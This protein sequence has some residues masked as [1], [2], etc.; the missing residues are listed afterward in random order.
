[1]SA[2]ALPA[3]AGFSEGGVAIGK[4]FRAVS[5]VA[6]GEGG[7]AKEKYSAVAQW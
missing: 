6:F 2:L 5:A 1:M 4:L 3:Q 7:V